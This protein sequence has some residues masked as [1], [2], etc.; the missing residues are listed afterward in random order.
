MLVVVVVTDELS[1]RKKVLAMCEC[2]SKVGGESR[3]KKEEEKTENK[4]RLQW[5]FKLK[6]LC[7]KV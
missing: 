5:I 7:T 1:N 2:R 6:V 3:T 4:V